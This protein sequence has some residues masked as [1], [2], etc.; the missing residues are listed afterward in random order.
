MGEA[1]ERSYLQYFMKH[2]GEAKMRVIEM[3]PEGALAGDLKHIEISSVGYM[4][5]EDEDL[6]DEVDL[7]SHP[8]WCHPE[9]IYC[10]DDKGNEVWLHKRPQ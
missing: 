7:Y 6:S 3:M 1:D 4:K 10:D 5:P 2:F 8:C 9:L